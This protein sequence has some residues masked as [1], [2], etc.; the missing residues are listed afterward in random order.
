MN[1]QSYLELAMNTTFDVYGFECNV[2]RYD[3]VK[4]ITLKVLESLRYD[5]LTETIN[6]SGV[7]LKT[8]IIDALN[9]YKVKFKISRYKIAAM[10]VCMVQTEIRWQVE[11]ILA[12]R[13]ITK[14]TKE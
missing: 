14:L 2:S 10:I 6:L 11:T 13:K 1:S 9:D 12:G 4:S 8:I 7:A 3:V 5:T